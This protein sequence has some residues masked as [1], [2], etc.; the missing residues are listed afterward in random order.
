MLGA[1]SETRARTRELVGVIN[2][3]A[4]HFVVWCY[5]GSALYAPR[6]Q[7]CRQIASFAADA[8]LRKLRLLD[9][10]I[11]ETRGPHLAGT[12]LTVADCVA[13]AT[14]QFAGSFYGVPIP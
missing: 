10:L 3:A 12:Q 13:M 6:V 7:Q 9:E 1:T 8:Y 5:H 4:N 2:E 11:S 14:L